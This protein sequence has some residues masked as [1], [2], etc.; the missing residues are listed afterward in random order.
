M[1]LVEWSDEKLSV[2]VG[3]IDRQHKKMI[4]MINELYDAVEAK[5]EKELLASLLIKLVH[6]THYHFATEEKYFKQHEY[7]EIA[8]HKEQHDQLREQVAALDDRYYTGHKMITSEVMKLLNDWLF[9]HI[10]GSDRKFGLF[11]N[12]KGTLTSG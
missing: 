1:P 9:D 3:M 11:L 8:V 2:R 10:I 5:R 12:E 6:Y 7:P 4:G